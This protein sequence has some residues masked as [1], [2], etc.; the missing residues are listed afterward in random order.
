MNGTVKTLL[1]ATLLSAG[2]S[3]QPAAAGLFGGAL[4]DVQAPHG[5]AAAREARIQAR[6]AAREQ[7][8]AERAVQRERIRQL[9]DEE[10]RALHRDLDK[11]NRE[12]YREWRP[13]VGVPA[14]VPPPG[15]APA[16]SAP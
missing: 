5:K 11:A 9:S 12:L 14:G 6:E 1:A 3:L 2:L 10:R 4:F 16:P 7:R 15:S 13:P 8:A